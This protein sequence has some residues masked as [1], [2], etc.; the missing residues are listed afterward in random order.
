MD[1]P[2]SIA[3]VLTGAP[4]LTGADQAEKRGASPASWA[5]SRRSRRSTRPTASLLRVLTHTS[6][7]PSVPTFPSRGAA[8]KYNVGPSND[9]AAPPS[10]LTL[11]IRR[12]GVAGVDHG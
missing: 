4:R 6:N 11:L 12:P 9:S 1:A 5:L 3:A 7:L 8:W 2:C 10:K